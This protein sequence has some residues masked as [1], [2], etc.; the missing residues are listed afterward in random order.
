VK[1]KVAKNKGISAV[2]EWSDQGYGKETGCAET[3]AGT[4]RNGTPQERRRRQVF[5]GK[6]DPGGRGREVILPDRPHPPKQVRD[7]GC[8]PWAQT[9]RCQRYAWKQGLR[10]YQGLKES[11]LRPHRQDRRGVREKSRMQTM[12]FPCLVSLPAQRMSSYVP[13][14]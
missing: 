2:G 6:D 5:C 4:R 13:F 8:R 3:H 7:E 11:Q 9:W 14:F 10:A 1:V 12:W